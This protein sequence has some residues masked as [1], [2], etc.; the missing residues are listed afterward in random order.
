MGEQIQKRQR[1]SEPWV[2]R[3]F[4]QTLEALA[5]CHE[6]GV[7]HKDLKFDNLMLRTVVTADSPIEDIHVMLIDVGLA[8]LFGPEHGKSTHSNVIAGTLITMAPEV[9]ARHF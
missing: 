3:V 9:I 2:A 8:E 6:K 1:F 5:Y 7:M 4:S